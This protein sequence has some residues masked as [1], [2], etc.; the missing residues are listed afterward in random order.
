MNLLVVGA[1]AMGRW[2][3]RTVDADVAFAD[4]DEAA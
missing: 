4:V 2:V 1:G 3:A